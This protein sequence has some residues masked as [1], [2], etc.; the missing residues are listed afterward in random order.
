[1]NPKSETNVM[2]NSKHIK[3]NKT[4]YSGLSAT[5]FIPD[6]LEINFEHPTK[7]KTDLMI[8]N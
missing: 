8:K 7:S 1:M 5:Y 4:V 3:E 2:L 6:I